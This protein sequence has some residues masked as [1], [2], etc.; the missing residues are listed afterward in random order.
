[1]AMKDLVDALAA[2]RSRALGMGGEEAVAKQHAAGKLTA[3]ERVDLLFDAGSFSE[4]GVHATHAGIAP[5]LAGRDTPADGMITGVGKIDGRFAAVIAYDFTVMA[6]SMG[7]TAEL[8][9]NRAREIA[10]T[11]RMPM[12]W[13]IDSAG[14]RIQE[15]IGSRNFAATG[16]LFREESIMSGVVPQ[17][18]AMM[19]PGAAGTAYIPAL[20]D[21]VPM[22]RGTSNMALGGPPLVKAVVGEDITA[23]ELGG[24]KVHCEISGCAD[25]EVADDRECLAV[26][27]EYLSYFP[28]S[29]RESPPVRACSDPVDRRAEELLTI[30]PDSPRRAYDVRKVLRAVVDDGHVFEMKPGW[31]KNIVTALARLGGHPVGLVA[32]QPLVLGGALD[33]DAADKA[34]RFIMLCDAFNVPLVFFQDVPGFMVGSKVERAGIIRHG[35]KMLYAVSEATVP[36]LT[37]VLRK[38]YGAGYYVMCG[39]AYEPDLIVAWPTAEISVMGPEGGTNIVFRREIAAAADPVAERARRVEDFRKL[40]DPYIAA[41][42]ALIDDVID[43][44]ETR[45]TLIRALEMARTKKVERPWRKHGVMPV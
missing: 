4:I 37:V 13:L 2:R 40:I 14:A 7:R 36:K 20:S 44:R 1:M 28:S 3:R 38:A 27:R 29:N 23:E 21:F 17:V 6:G 30:V 16:L 41:G 9:G 11:K 15:A 5:D 33:N 43:P 45:P 19:G 8:K 10:L 32:S 25:L 22:V 12:I 26:I 31:A 24:S 42:A 34:A 35:A 39:R 18:A